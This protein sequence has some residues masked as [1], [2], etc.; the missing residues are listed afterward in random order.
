[1]ENLPER[2]FL[3]QWN[4]LNKWEQ[5][6]LARMLGILVEFHLDV[7]PLLYPELGPIHPT[8]Q[9]M[10]NLYNQIKHQANHQN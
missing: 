2:A 1:M 4:R 7:Y 10:I 8:F 3:Q 6:V 9:R 5:G